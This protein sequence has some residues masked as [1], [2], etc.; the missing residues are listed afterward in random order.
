MYNAWGKVVKNL[1]IHSRLAVDE[2]PQKLPAPTTYRSNTVYNHLVLPV[3]QTA[4][5]RTFPQYFFQETL[6][7]RRLFSPLSTPPITITTN[8]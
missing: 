4:F 6:P 7:L 2:Y 3:L 1:R 5:T 8:L